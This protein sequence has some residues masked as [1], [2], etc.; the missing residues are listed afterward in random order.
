MGEIKEIRPIERIVYLDGDSDFEVRISNGD[1]GLGNADCFALR[2]WGGS[3]VY[4]TRKDWR[5]IQLAVQEYFEEMAESE[6]ELSRER[7][8]ES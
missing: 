5:Q 1:D 6:A 2:V 8:K 3:D 4:I 7:D